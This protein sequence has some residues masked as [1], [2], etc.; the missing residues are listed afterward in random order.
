MLKGWRGRAPMGPGAACARSL[1][2]PPQGARR[3]KLHSEPCRECPGQARQETRISLSPRHGRP[4]Q[5]GLH[6]HVHCALR[7]AHLRRRASSGVWPRWPAGRLR[8]CAVRASAREGRV[9]T[10][11]PAF[12]A[13]L[14]S[15]PTKHAASRQR[16]A[17]PNMRPFVLCAAASCCC[18]F[19]ENCPNMALS[20]ERTCELER[21]SSAR[22]PEARGQIQR[23]RRACRRRRS[24]RSGHAPG[25]PA[26]SESREPGAGSARTAARRAPCAVPH[27]AGRM[28]CALQGGVQRAASIAESYDQ[29]SARPGQGT[30]GQGAAHCCARCILG[31]LGILGE[32]GAP[33]PFP[34]PAARSEVH[35]NGA[36]ASRAWHARRAARALALPRAGL[37]FL[38]RASEQGEWGRRELGSWELGAGEGEGKGEQGEEGANSAPTLGAIQR[39]RTG[40]ARGAR[41]IPSIPS[42]SAARRSGALNRPRRPRLARHF[43]GSRARRARRARRGR[44]SWAVAMAAAAAA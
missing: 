1:K 44:G 4:E 39:V 24:A 27:T 3:T 25:A 29:R 20:R 41:R 16:R 33:P 2:R 14:A 43:A 18:C 38:E 12:L 6:A 28:R 13:F 19:W 36:D 23:W 30:A 34:Q 17:E 15:L 35:G 37:G 8:S 40:A 7:I 5:R 22:P 11:L 21:A 31:L 9:P 42:T 32:H 10:F 26:W